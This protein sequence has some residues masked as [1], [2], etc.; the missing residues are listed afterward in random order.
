MCVPFDP[1][2]RLVG[3]VCLFPTSSYFS[4]LLSLF[5]FRA[6]RPI[7]ETWITGQSQCTGSWDQISVGSNLQWQETL[8]F[9][10][11]RHN[12]T[13]SDGTFWLIAIAINQNVPSERV[14]LCRFLGNRSLSCFWRRSV[15]CDR[16]ANIKTSTLCWALFRECDSLL[17]PG[18]TQK[19]YRN[20]SETPQE[21]P[22]NTLETFQERLKNTPETPQKHHRNTSE[23]PQERFRNTSGIPQKHLRNTPETPLL[24]CA[25][26]RLHTALERQGHEF[27]PGRPG[28]TA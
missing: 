16:A 21:H 24:W 20:T 14:E 7:A 5:C 15:K 11:N 25:L 3:P 18:T 19:H 23:T 4:R 1:P 12:S 26:V 9:H 6:G 22:R 28:A 27:S 2:R 17:G 10:W 8:L 13:L